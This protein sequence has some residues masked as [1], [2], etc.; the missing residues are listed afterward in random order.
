MMD[1][2]DMAPP[3]R[4]VMRTIRPRLAG[5]APVAVWLVLLAGVAAAEREDS[6]MTLDLRAV[7]NMGWQD[8]V[9]GD[10]KGGWTDQGDNDMRQV[11]PGRQVNRVRKMGGAGGVAVTERHVV[12]TGVAVAVG[13]EAQVPARGLCGPNHPGESVCRPSSLTDPIPRK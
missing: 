5:L 6:F 7:V 11:T 2:I 9:A 8:E 1:V 10:G 3:E 4:Q 13:Q 12:P